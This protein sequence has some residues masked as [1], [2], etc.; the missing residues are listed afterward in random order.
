METL[1]FLGLANYPVK[2]DAHYGHADQSSFS[3]N[4][5][6]QNGV[7]RFGD[8]GV[9]DAEDADVIVHEYTH[10]LN[11]SINPS[12]ISG[13]EREAIEEGSCDFIALTYSRSL[14]NF[15]Y[16]KI[17]NWDGH[18]EFWIGRSLT[19]TRSY[20]SDLENYLYSDAPL[21]TSALAEIHDYFGRTISERL[22]FSSTYSYF[23]YMTMTA[24][25]SLYLQADTLLYGAAH[26]DV[27]S[28]I[29][30]NRG[31]L[32][33][34]QDT[35]INEKPLSDPYLAGSEPFAA[36]SGPLRLFPNKRTL[37]SLELIDLSG[38]RLM[39]QEFSNEMKLFYEL[40][41]PEIASGYYVLWVQT[42]EGSFAFKLLKQN[43]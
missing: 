35:L 12:P 40:D 18:N 17:F 16:D 2:V 20:P 6:E 14:S 22:L 27:I 30:C 9:D 28:I 31:L 3:F 19:N 21:W 34:C 36:N 15:N 8:G 43:N 1:G 32:E 42:T 4:E 33:G 23:P 38:K 7:L 37:L 11:R 24:A 41:F 26:T 25:A 13:N 10:A 5:I 29:F 39:H